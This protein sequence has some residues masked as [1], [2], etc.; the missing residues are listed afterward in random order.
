MLMSLRLAL[1][2]LSLLC[3]ASAA[4]AAVYEVS[5]KR[6]M[7]DGQEIQLFGVNWFGAETTDHVPHGLWSRNYEDMI[8]QIAGLGFNA[9]RLPFCPTTLTNVTPSSIDYS[10][11]TALQGLGSLEVLDEVVSALDA[12]G[13]YILF[14]HHRPDCNSI[15]ELWYTA[16]YSESDWINDLVFVATRYSGTDH[17]IGIDLKN[18]PHG[19]ATWGTGNAATDWNEAAERASAAILAANPNPLIFVE[20]IAENSSCSSSSGHWWGGNL[21]PEACSPLDISASKLVFSPHVYGP[22]VFAQSY[23]NDPNFPGNLPAI[24]D[25]HFGFIADQGRVVAP[26]EFGGRYGHGGAATDVAWQDELIDYFIDKQICHFFY[27]SWNPNSGDTGGILQDDWT[28]IWQDKF[29]NLDRLMTSCRA[30][31]AVETP[32][33]GLPARGLL[34]VLVAAGGWM[35][36]RRRFAAQHQIRGARGESENG[37]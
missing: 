1:S 28:Q 3:I 21:E 37:P 2:I 14:D 31:I 33:L 24:W 25:T 12:A 23:F 26:G 8:D 36:S 27:W 13:I 35:A 16:T 18:E 20:G 32:A 5:G 19:A 10:Q 9:V 6:L 30:S 34:L 17:F 11:N 7:R 4:T 15:S 29:D 22:D